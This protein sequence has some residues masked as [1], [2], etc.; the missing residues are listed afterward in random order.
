[1]RLRENLQV[2]DGDSPGTAVSTPGRFGEGPD[3]PHPG[4]VPNARG[5]D[6]LD[7]VL[8]FFMQDRTCTEVDQGTGP[9]RVILFWVRLQA[10]LLQVFDQ[11]PLRVQGHVSEPYELVLPRIREA[12]QR[13]PVHEVCVDLSLTIE[14]VA[15]EC[16]RQ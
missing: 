7:V 10:V 6:E 15:V 3:A 1:M 13:G 14:E 11:P 8:E 5:L 4:I 16:L 9:I 12:H 2:R